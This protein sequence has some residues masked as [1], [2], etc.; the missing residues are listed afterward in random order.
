VKKVDEVDGDGNRV[1]VVTY[2]SGLTE[3]S[4]TFDGRCADYSDAEIQAVVAGQEDRPLPMSNSDILDY[5][6]QNISES[7]IVDQCYG[8]LIEAKIIERSGALTQG[9]ASTFDEARLTK[10]KSEFGDNWIIEAVAFYVFR[11]FKTYSLEF[12]AASALY[13]TYVLKRPFRAGYITAEMIWKFR[14]ESFA[15]LGQKNKKA[16][17]AAD[18]AKP[19]KAKERKKQKLELVAKIWHQQKTELGANAMLKDTNAA[20]AIHIN[21][22][23]HQYPEL[24]I[25]KTGKIIGVDA[26]K[27]LLPKLRE[28]GQIDDYGV[29]AKFGK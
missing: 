25:K 2:S 20:Q 8:L 12:Y 29:I 9:V 27:R 11:N 26:I 19:I 18:A 3:N 28:L 13:E 23:K 21:A 16:L 5:S 7:D 10:L 1:C 15:I 6:Y 22:E 17:Q 4:I 14:H 24:L